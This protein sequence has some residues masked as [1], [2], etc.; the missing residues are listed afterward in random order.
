[1]ISSLDSRVMDANCEALGISVTTLM[2]NAGKAVADFL[3]SRYP[4]KRTLFVC[5]P[6]NN[7]GD[8]FAAA[9][10]MDRRR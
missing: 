3:I 10:L 4:G 8:G 2:G 7:G 6:G 5:G 9:C 1:M